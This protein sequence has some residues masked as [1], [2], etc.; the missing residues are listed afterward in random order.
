[1]LQRL[2]FDL[3]AVTLGQLGTAVYLVRGIEDV[4]ENDFHVA[5][6]FLLVVG[7]IGA[8]FEGFVFPR[9]SS[10]VLSTAMPILS[11]LACSLPIQLVTTPAIARLE[12]NL[13]YGSVALVEISTQALYYVVAVP[14]AVM[15]WN[16]WSLAIAW[17][18]Q[19]GT[20]FILFHLA[21]RWIRSQRGTWLFSKRMLAYASD[22]LLLSL[23][24]AIEITR[25]FGD[26]G[27]SARR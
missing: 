26:R 7:I 4:N 5:S 20:A 6:S 13:N 9:M 17:L 25:K 27:K 10:S 18:V 21:G 12:R 23:D 22:F 2:E 15:G 3:F 19:Q 16:S 14:L 8:F 1:M 24:W 11:L